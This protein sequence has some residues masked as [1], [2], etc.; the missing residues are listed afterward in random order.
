MGGRARPVWRRVGRRGGRWVDGWARR[1]GRRV[2]RWEHG[3]GG[4]VRYD[5]VAVESA[6][7][8]GARCAA[9]GADVVG[10]SAGG[11]DAACGPEVAVVGAG[12]EPAS[13]TEAA[14]GSGVVPAG[15][16]ADVASAG[17]GRAAGLR[18]WCRRRVV[19]GRL[20]CGGIR[21]GRLRF[22]GRRRG[23]C[24]GRPDVLVRVG[25]LLLVRHRPSSRSGPP[26]GGRPARGRSRAQ[27]LPRAPRPAVRRFKQIRPRSGTPCQGCSAQ[28]LASVAEPSPGLPQHRVIVASGHFGC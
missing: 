12:S 11:A 15:A 23:I 24:A 16:C 17:S 9:S 14:G 28:R 1:G 20:R 7:D 27:R 22:G 18:R 25:A 2:G 21:V 6:G 19:R 8:A 3:I 5:G 4:G 10:A 13:D 26:E